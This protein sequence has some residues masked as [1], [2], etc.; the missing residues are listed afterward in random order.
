MEKKEN[1]IAIR[2]RSISEANKAFDAFM[3]KTERCFNE[4]SDAN[5]NLYKGI[6][7]DELEIITITSAK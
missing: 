7:S 3:Q 2:K 1:I 4:R 6:S 5:P